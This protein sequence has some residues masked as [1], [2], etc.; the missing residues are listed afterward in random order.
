MLRG[1]ELNARREMVPMDALESDSMSE[2][3]QEQSETGINLALENVAVN[4]VESQ[5]E[6]RIASQ[7]PTE[8]MT[9]AKIN[10]ELPG[11]RR[12]FSEPRSQS[13]YAN[14]GQPIRSGQNTPGE[15]MLSQP[16]SRKN[17]QSQL[18]DSTEVFVPGIQ[19]RRVTWSQSRSASLVQQHGRV[20][21]VKDRPGIPHTLLVGG[22]TEEPIPASQS[23]NS[24]YSVVTEY[25][26]VEPEVSQSVYLRVRSHQPSVTSDQS[27]EGQS[28]RE[29]WCSQSGEDESLIESRRFSRKLKSPRLRR[30]RQ[31]DAQVDTLYPTTGRGL[32]DRGQVPTGRLR[33]TNSSS[34]S[35]SDG[36][37]RRHG[38]QTEGSHRVL[39][40][41]SLQK[42]RDVLWNASQKDRLSPELY[43]FSEPELPG[44][45]P[46]K[47]T[48]KPSLK[49]QRSL[50]IPEAISLGPPLRSPVRKH[51][52]PPPEYSPPPSDFKDSPLESLLERA[53][54]RERERE[55]AKRGNRRKER[56]T[57]PPKGPSPPSLST[58]PSPLP[59][60]GDRE[61]DGDEVDSTRLQVTGPFYGWR[62]GN[63]DGSDDERTS[64]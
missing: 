27:E 7:Q 35:D 14:L 47:K 54:G 9:S 28:R 49:N 38:K 55:G 51:S 42:N 62:E 45:E 5:S 26:S 12:K 37:H 19:E 61:M 17:S 48:H 60:D 40:L 39:K 36:S 29:S 46:A 57:A 13:L 43:T 10:E 63:V 18:W 11:K 4:L 56:P 53:K 44:R 41:G 33:N 1:S 64:R 32:V 31:I 52:R 20:A 6:E 23:V 15:G 3:Q 22:H 8:E 24:T 25:V 58:T 59:S 21:P 16:G 2:V 50:S 34:N 30:R